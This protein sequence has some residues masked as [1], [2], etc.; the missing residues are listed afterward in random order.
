MNQKQRRLSKRRNH[1]DKLGN[2]LENISLDKKSTPNL[3]QLYNYLEKK[4]V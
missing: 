2:I 4:L 1:E 3:A